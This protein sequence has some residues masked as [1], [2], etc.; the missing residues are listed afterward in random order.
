M[1][2]RLATILAAD[3]VGYSRLMEL[4]EER[5][6][7]ALRACRITIA[8]L[9]EKH[10]GRIFGGAGDSLVAEFA[11][12]VEAVRAGFEIQ[13]DLA[14]ATLDLPE[15]HAMQFRIGINLGD[16]MVDR[17]DLFG[18]G[19]NVAARL[20]ALADAGGICISGNVHE[21]VEGKLRFGFEDL[22]FHELKNITRPIRVFRARFGPTA[23]A[24]RTA[25]RLSSTK[26]SIAVLPF[27]NMSTDPEQVYFS[28]GITEDI[29]TEL[30]RFRQLF[31]IARHSSF[32]YRDKAADVLRIGRE[33]NARYVVEGSVRRSGDRIRIS[34]QLID[35][36]TG[37]HVWVERYDS[38]LTDLFSI[39]DE[40]TKR[41]V[42][43]LA[44]R[45]EEEDWAKA[46]RKPPDRMQAYDFWLRGK[47][48]LDLYTREGNLEARQLF[49]KALEIDPDYARAHAGLALTYD[50]GG[51]YSAWDAN[52]KTSLQKAESHA[53]KAVALDDT[54]PLPHVILGWVHHGRREFDRAKE[55]LERAM[56]INPNDADTLAKSAL[57]LAWSG[58]GAAVIE[59]AEAA[60]RL[61]PH[62]PGWYQCF[63]AGC[64]L[65]AGRYAE[66][67]TIWE[68]IPDATPETRAMLAAAC[69]FLGRLE[70]AQRHMAEFIRAYPRHFAGAPNARHVRCLFEFREEAE[71]NRLIEA[72]CKAGLPA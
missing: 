52:P 21:Q 36:A 71:V 5:T 30:A 63:L 44:V 39:Q 47:R 62:F 40:V 25:A 26:P 65:C 46:R 31:V 20:E 2:R 18:D 41:I 24:I 35:A 4:D 45:V 48:S 13:S 27:D 70:D 11:S 60:I 59:L 7:S 32:R 38:R 66:A 54:D 14:G 29:I 68:R 34:A 10:G 61:N 28:D 55:H 72:M 12:P 43:A 49:E 23:P 3:V 64:H 56:A 33:L 6:Y 1:E 57:A 69:V 17:E 19:V 51:F 9:I 8:G 37:T 53:K 15:G 16:V 58:D 22:G 50:R 67:V 42:V